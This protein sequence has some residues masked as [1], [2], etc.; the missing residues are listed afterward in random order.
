MAVSFCVKSLRSLSR[1]SAWAWASAI[2]AAFVL[3]L[4]APALLGRRPRLAWPRFFMVPLGGSIVSVA[5]LALPLARRWAC[6]LAGAALFGASAR[7]EQNAVPRR[8]PA[9]GLLRGLRWRRSFVR[10]RRAL[11]FGFGQC[12]RARYAPKYQLSNRGRCGAVRGVAGSRGPSGLYAP[13]ERSPGPRGP[14]G[15]RRAAS[16]GSAASPRRDVA[17]RAVSPPQPWAGAPPTSIS[18]RLNTHVVPRGV[19]KAHA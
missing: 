11:P 13:P 2:L 1:C 3:A 4:I 10:C 9:A 17:R 18:H 19:S 14:L 15:N 6:R 12:F 5:V 8:A 7:S 16:A